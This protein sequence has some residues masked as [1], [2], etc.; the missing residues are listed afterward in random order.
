MILEKQFVVLYSKDKKIINAIH[1]NSYTSVAGDLLGVEFDTQ[2]DMD[3]F[4][5][6]NNLTYD[7]ITKDY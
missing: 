3:A 2:E 1:D 6:A 4:I 5:Y 7:W